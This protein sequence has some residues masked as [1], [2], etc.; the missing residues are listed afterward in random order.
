MSECTRRA[1]R[2]V[3]VKSIRVAF[4][5]QGLLWA[6][7]SLEK[8]NRIDFTYCSPL[9]GWSAFAPSEYPCSPTSLSIAE[10]M[11]SMTAHAVHSSP[12]H[13][14]RILAVQESRQCL[15]MRNLRGSTALLKYPYN[16]CLGEKASKYMTKDH[17]HLCLIPSRTMPQWTRHSS[18]LVC[19]P[20]HCAC[21]L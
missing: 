8:I 12:P 21:F 5:V 6:K 2:C 11:P 15:G 20:H 1:R 13:L 9:S 19:T 10:N 3:Q 17:T 4:I 16:R 14:F 18:S 7:A